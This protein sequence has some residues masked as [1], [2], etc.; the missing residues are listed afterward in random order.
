MSRASSSN[1]TRPG[2]N[3]Q[4]EADR[5][6][7]KPVWDVLDRVFPRERQNPATQ[8]HNKAATV[9]FLRTGQAAWL[10]QL[11]EGEVE[12][13]D[14]A[15]PETCRLSCSPSRLTKDSCRRASSAISPS[16]SKRRKKST[17]RQKRW[18]PCTKRP[19]T[20]RQRSL[21]DLLRAIVVRATALLKGQKWRHLPLSTGERRLGVCLSYNL[22]PDFKG[23]VLRA[24][25]GVGQ[26]A[27]KRPAP[28]RKPITGGPD[29][30]IH[31]AP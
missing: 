23:T 6:T 24:R 7:G 22:E 20:W 19:S 18:P 4:P 5:S 3:H 30:T 21:P 16:A 14:G 17:I 10:N 12:R 15:R 2:A 27:G 25:G 11:T 13:S 8:E 1:G 9:E 29:R 31:E 26:G 28:D